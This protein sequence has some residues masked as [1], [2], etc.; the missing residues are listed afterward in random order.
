MDLSGRTCPLPIQ[1]FPLVV[2]GHGGGGKLSAELVEHLFLPAF[3]M[4]GALGDAA[5]LQVGEEQL[6]FST[7]SFVVTPLFFPGGNIGELAVNGTINDLAMMGGKPLYLSCGFILEEGFSIEELSRIAQAM[8]RA[9]REAGVRL[10]T[11]DTK[12]VERGHGHGV[13]I[14]TSGIGLIPPGRKV[15]PG[16]ARPGDAVIVSGPIGNHGMAVMSVREGLE[17][18]TTIE[19]DT[20]ALHPLVELLMESPEEIRALRD[21]TRG[22]IA[23]ALN[24]LAAASHVSIVL[25]ESLIPVD[26]SVRAACELLGLDPLY[27]ANEGKLLA[28]V[29][30]EKADVIVKKLRSH[31]LGE[32]ACVI[33]KVV[34]EHPGLVGMRTTLGATRLVDTQIGE[35][36][37][38]IC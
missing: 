34:A 11:G 35:Q 3:G 23:S 9:A 28:I 13:Y 5:V 22:G 24:E 10:V 29:E 25:E 31:A 19:S 38:R 6:C 18:E 20:A 26:D 2:L 30:C 17:F 21:P 32:G 12:V 7:D 14:N 8:G 1:D 36:L 4:D 27:V 33:G 15:G 16:R 37:P